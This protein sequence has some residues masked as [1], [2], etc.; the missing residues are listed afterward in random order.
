MSNNLKV[1]DIIKQ[2]EN[3]KFPIRTNNNE[4]LSGDK[5]IVSQVDNKKNDRTDRPEEKFSYTPSLAVMTIATVPLKLQDQVS[6]NVI[7]F[8][9]FRFFFD[10]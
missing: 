7:F 3:T 8:I 9:D 5:E 4:N 6:E 10:I 1:S 2:L